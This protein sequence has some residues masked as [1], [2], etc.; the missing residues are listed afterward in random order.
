MA[1]QVCANGDGDCEGTHVSVDAV[2]NKGKYDD[3]LNWPFVGKISFTLL[4]QLKDSNHHRMTFDI[5]T[6]HNLCVKS[7][8]GILNSSPTPSWAMTQSRTPSTSRTMLS[9]SGCQSNQ[10]FRNLGW[11]EQNCILSIIMYIVI[12]ETANF[13]REELANTAILNSSATLSW[14][15]TQLPILHS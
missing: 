6:A 12:I 3:E 11:S 15:M 8:W 2:I 14:A 1:L 13:C 5:T 10:L 7:G 9:T 4:N